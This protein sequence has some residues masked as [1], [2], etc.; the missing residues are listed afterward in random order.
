MFSSFDVSNTYSGCDA[1][2][3]VYLETLPQDTI[4]QI[5]LNSISKQK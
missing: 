1:H 4:N 5:I 3:E 2:T